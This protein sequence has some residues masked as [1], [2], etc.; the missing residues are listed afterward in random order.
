MS[1]IHRLNDYGLV[2][3]YLQ[4]RRSRCADDDGTAGG[5]VPPLSLLATSAAAP[6]TAAQH[7][8]LAAHDD[9]LCRHQKSFFAHWK[10]RALVVG[11]SCWFLMVVFMYVPSI[12]V[13]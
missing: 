5:I 12:C 10:P 13:S 3:A 2:D 1:C 4:R 6:G 7:P 8:L 11:V 9:G